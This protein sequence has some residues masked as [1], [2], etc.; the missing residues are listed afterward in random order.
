MRLSPGP[1]SERIVIDPAAFSLFGQVVSAASCGDLVG[2]GSE[3]GFDGG[4]KLPGGAGS[5]T[6]SAHKR[7][8][9]S[10]LFQ[11]SSVPI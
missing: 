11:N 6:D 1:I 2:Q 8:A 10:I 7:A 5:A 3:P 4:E 9:K